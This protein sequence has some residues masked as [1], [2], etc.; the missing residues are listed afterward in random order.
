MHRGRHFAITV[1]NVEKVVLR[2]E[3][4]NTDLLNGMT[5]NII[6]DIKMPHM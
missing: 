3:D 4:E 1:S 5:N 2:D 6:G